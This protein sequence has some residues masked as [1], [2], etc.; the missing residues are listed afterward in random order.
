MTAER[1]LYWNAE[2]LRGCEGEKNLLRLHKSSKIKVSKQNKRQQ[3]EIAYFVQYSFS[4]VNFVSLL[5][6]VFHPASKN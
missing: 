3:S 1:R 4:H 2:N 5:E 6:N